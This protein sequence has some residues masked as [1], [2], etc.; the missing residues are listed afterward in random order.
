MLFF[1]NINFQSWVSTFG[2]GFRTPRFREGI[3]IGTEGLGE[4]GNEEMGRYQ[5]P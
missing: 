5:V 1:I 2:L 3:G 4:K